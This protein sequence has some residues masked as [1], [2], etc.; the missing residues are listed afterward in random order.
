[1]APID[2][3]AASRHLVWNLSRIIYW[4]HNRESGARNI[5]S[6]YMKIIREFYLMGLLDELGRDQ[7]D[8][9]ATLAF[10][11]R[12]I[13]EDFIEICDKDQK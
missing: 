5:S 13:P 12:H 10:F 7:E 8:A 9:E 1:M 3:L 2:P 4:E 6:A 11:K